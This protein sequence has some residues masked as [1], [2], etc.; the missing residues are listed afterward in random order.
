M[1]TVLTHLI[2]GINSNKSTKF[3]LVLG[4]ANLSKNFLLRGNVLVIQKVRWG[5]SIKMIMYKGVRNILVSKSIHLLINMYVGII[6]PIS[7]LI[8]NIIIPYW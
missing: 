2:G 6:L 5:N 4:S 8:G 7:Y 1:V 3:A